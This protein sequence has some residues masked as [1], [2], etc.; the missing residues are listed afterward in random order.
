MA[1]RSR[2]AAVGGGDRG[3]RA[4]D[5][6]GGRM[7]AIAFMTAVRV[8]AEIA[9]VHAQLEQIELAVEQRRQQNDAKAARA[10]AVACRGVVP[11]AQDLGAW[12]WPYNARHVVEIA[13]WSKERPCASL[14]AAL[15]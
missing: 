6:G 12:H 4:G 2:Q 5:R 14:N 3:D 9:G 1:C 13:Q 10:H 7:T 8:T 11:S 15:D